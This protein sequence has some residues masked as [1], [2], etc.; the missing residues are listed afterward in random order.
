MKRPFLLL[1]STL[2]WL[3]IPLSL[4]AQPT[5]LAPTRFAFEPNLPYNPNIPSPSQAF[6]LQLGQWLTPYASIAQYAV[7]VAASTDRVV[8]GN[9]GQTYEGRPLIYCVVTHPD[10]MQRLDEI[11]KQNLRFSDPQN[12]T[13]AEARAQMENSPVVVSFSYNIHGNEASSSEAAM[14]V[15]YR[16]AAAQDAETE[17]MLR[18]MVF[19]MYICINPDGRDRYVQWYNSVARTYPATDPY[20]LEHDAPWPNGRTNHYWFDLNRDWIWGVHPES[21]GQTRIY[22]DWMPQV[23]V[24]YHE[25][26]YNSNYFTM[27]GTT[28]RNKLLP[29]AYERMTDRFGRANG[30]A[31]DEA[32]MNYFTRESFDFFYPGYGSSY[33]SVNGAIGMLTEQGGIG[34]GRVIETNDGYHLLLRQRIWDHYTTSI[35]TLKQAVAMRTTLINYQYEAMN[36]ANSKSPIK[37]YILPNDP[38]SYLY[39][40]LEI[41]MHHRIQI[42]RTTESV[43]VSGATDYLTGNPVSKTFPAGTYIVST[44][45]PR[46]LLINSIMQRE[47]DIE[48]SVMYDMATWSAPLAYQLE[49]YSSSRAIPTNK[50]EAVTTPPSYPMALA[51]PQAKYAYVVPGTQRNAPLA[52]SLLHREGYRVRVAAK[53]FRYENTEYPAGSLIVLNGRNRDRLDSIAFDMGSIAQQA[54]VQIVGMNTGRMDAGIDLASND[55]V[56]I[57]APRVAM[58]VDEPF[59][60]Y[61]AGFIYYLFDQELQYPIH[62]IRAGSLEETDLPKFGSRYGLA[63]LQD[64][65]VLILP[66]GGRYLSK[67]FGEEGQAALNRWIEAGGT[68]IAT[69]S[70][71][72]FFTKDYEVTDV[73]IRQEPDGNEEAGYLAYQDRERYYGLRSVPGTALLG[74]LDTSHPLAFGLP[75]S[76]Y[77][78]KFGNTALEPSSEWQ[79]VGYYVKNPDQLKVSGYI[80]AENREHL[81][82]GAFAGVLD[83]GEGRVVYLTDN[84]QYRMF[85]RGS[86]R[87]LTNAAF[88]MPGF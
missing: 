11:R 15:L 18:N 33:P 37:A 42:H 57:K 48:D 59:N 35:A 72:T 29:D 34:A 53:S 14:Q 76:I 12:F 80:S 47:M 43:Q 36:P 19:I 5:N 2:F 7:G 86:S 38:N 45:Q 78:L 3:S 22:Q 85:W 28:P 13:E 69:E 25:Q 54:Q 32:Q 46:H 50:L 66:G 71:A 75:K 55:A 73:E 20:E 87:L 51:N 82:G 4:M 1:L 9:Y 88:F 49:A 70:A 74:Q 63:T 8:V 77:A 17:Q 79:T 41:L 83:M 67:V 52:L 10:N 23:H 40:V 61:S 84:T 58:L 64:Y 24:D 16:L 44:D 60:T 62:R 26:G 30:K 68:L 21:R 31:F 65:D 6:G 56:P 39:D 81:A 27:P